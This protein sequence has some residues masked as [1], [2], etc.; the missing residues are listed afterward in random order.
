MYRELAPRPRPSR[1]RSSPTASACTPTPC[2]CTSSAC[3]RRPRR[4]RGRPPRH[5]RP[6][7]ARLLARARRARARVR[8]ARATRCSPACS[9]RW[10][11]AS[12]PTPTTPP[13]T[14]RVV[15][16]R[17]R[18]RAP[19]LAACVKRAGGRAGPARV[20]ARARGRRHRRRRRPTS[21]SCTARSASW[22]RPT[23]SSS[24]TCTGDLRRRGRRGRRG[25]SRGVRDVVRPA[26]RA[27]STVARRSTLISLNRL[28][29]HCEVR[30]SPS[31]RQ[32][33]HP[34]RAASDQGQEPDR[35]RG[36]ARARTCGSRCAP[37]AAPGFSYEMFFDTEK[38][39]DDIEVEL[40]RRHRSSSTPRARS[41]SA[42]RRS[43]TRTASRAPG[44]RSTTR[45]RSAPAAAAS[46][47]P[48]DPPARTCVAPARVVVVR[49]PASSR[50]RPVARDVSA[51]TLR[52]ASMTFVFFACAVQ[53]GEGSDA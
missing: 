18:A 46:R 2:A 4:R 3:A 15:G 43:T 53:C 7:P 6:P 9:R 37:A 20:R 28:R 23:P 17:G 52:A 25:K 41:T 1:P 51:V 32:M 27:R 33:I 45:T 8:P 40:R 31:G 38:A 24:A 14:G 49:R 5:G 39:A 26:T 30:C 44:S 36:Q 21:S 10:P 34:D 11:S 29:S 48:D 35:G 42:A 47:S 19:G 13:T 12:A 22:P 50:C 16:H